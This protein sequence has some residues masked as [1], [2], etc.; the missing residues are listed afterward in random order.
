MTL[1]V[2][3]APA[4]GLA[5]L[6]SGCCNCFVP[7]EAETTVVVVPSRH[8]GHVGAVLVTNAGNQR[9]LL[10]TA[11]ATAQVAATGRVKQA[12]LKSRKMKALE[13]ELA[14]AREALPPKV[15]TYTLYFD[16]ATDTLTEESSRTL[17][18]ILS[19]VSGRP[20]AEIICVGHSDTL[21]DA[22]A[23][24][25]LSLRRAQRMRKFVIE[26]GAP[27]TIVTAVGVGEADLIIATPDNVEEPRN[28]R[29]EITVR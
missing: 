6:L 27:E 21:G 8:D 1:G 20:A 13:A 9:Q 24:I 14:A 18:T 22:E 28:R 4:T 10:N 3:R 12:P 17:D 29:V 25:E 7:Q 5:L 23:N 16:L 19:E 15:Q 2:Y 26:R 11:N